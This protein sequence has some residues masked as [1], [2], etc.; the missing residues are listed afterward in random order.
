M[1][2]KDFTGFRVQQ[3]FILQ[4]PITKMKGTLYAM[5]P[6]VTF[7]VTWYMTLGCL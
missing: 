7:L 6:F 4:S 2:H 1:Y 3:H 5:T